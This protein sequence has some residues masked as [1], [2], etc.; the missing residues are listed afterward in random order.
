MA[1]KET[2]KKP[3]VRSHH[4]LAQYDVQ[5][6]D[7]RTGRLIRTEKKFVFPTKADFMAHLERAKAQNPAHWDIVKDE[8]LAA[9]ETYE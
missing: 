9:A 4:T 5:I 8:L 1:E 7:E 6:T 2:E 3:K